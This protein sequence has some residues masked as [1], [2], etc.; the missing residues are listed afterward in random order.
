MKLVR[1]VAALIVVLLAAP[2]VLLSA[3]LIALLWPLEKLVRGAVDLAVWIAGV[4]PDFDWD[5]RYPRG[6]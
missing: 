5:N 2:L 4:K 1:V 6:S 3:V